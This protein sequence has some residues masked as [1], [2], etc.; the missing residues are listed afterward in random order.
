MLRSQNILI[1]LQS[2]PYGPRFLQR[3][4]TRSQPSRVRRSA[5]A[6]GLVCD[7][8]RITTFW[9]IALKMLEI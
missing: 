7:Q 8:H 3:G 1:L 9:R 5:R 4:R 6:N 2:S